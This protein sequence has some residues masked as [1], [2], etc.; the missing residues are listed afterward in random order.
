MQTQQATTDLKLAKIEALANSIIM[1]ANYCE[2]SPDLCRVHIQT[3]ASKIL[4]IIREA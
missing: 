3:D 4:S 2:D 1:E